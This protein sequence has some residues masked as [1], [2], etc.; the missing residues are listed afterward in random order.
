[1]QNLRWLLWFLG[2]HRIPDHAV[3]WVHVDHDRSIVGLKADAAAQLPIEALRTFEWVVPDFEM[4]GKVGPFEV[5]VHPS[6]AQA[7]FWNRLREAA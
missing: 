1:M 5:M 3:T 2:E 6:P 4:I 7:P